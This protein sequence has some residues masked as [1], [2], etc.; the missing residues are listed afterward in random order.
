[1]TISEPAALKF[2]S[3]YEASRTAD[4]HLPD[5]A[6]LNDHN[7]DRNAP[8]ATIAIFQ[9]SGLVRPRCPHE[10]S[11]ESPPST[12]MTRRSDDDDERCTDAPRI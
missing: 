2:G 7:R 4:L 11:T 9:A 3:N 5:A 1:M 12:T 6:L 10:M 8:I